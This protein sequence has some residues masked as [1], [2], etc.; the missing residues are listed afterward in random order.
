[1]ITFDDAYLDFAEHAWPALKAHDLPVMLFVP[2][3]F[4]D[5][6]ERV[7]W[8]DRLEHAFEQ[9][10]RREEISSPLGPLAL[11]SQDQRQSSHRR[12]KHYLKTLQS[13]VAL[14]VTAEVCEALDVASPRSLV[15]GWNDLRQLANEGVTLGA[16]S[17]THPF[18]SR[19]T[20]EE[21]HAEIAGSLDDLKREIGE[22]LPY[23]AYPD[24]QYNHHTVE[25]LGEC[26]VE[27]AFTTETGA[28]DLS[29]VDPLQLRRLYVGPREKLGMVRARLIHSALTRHGSSR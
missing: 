3:A 27:I 9:T 15:L 18:M 29:D 19:L 28:N 26:G 6:P 5:C 10:K 4:P 2:T 24:G 13:E 25:I 22:D 11:A 14:R 23:F 17:Q 21:A 1:M 16:H 12:L 7:F 20:R 8:W